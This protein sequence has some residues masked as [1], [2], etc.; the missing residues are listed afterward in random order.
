MRPHPSSVNCPYCGAKQTCWFYDGIDVGVSKC[1]GC[2][3]DM[4]LVQ[5]RI[6]GQPVTTYGAYPLEE[7]EAAALAAKGNVGRTQ[8]PADGGKLAKVA[9]LVKQQ[10][11]KNRG[12]PV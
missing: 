4:K 5:R 7:A 9:A 12:G 11:R 3:R 6:P 10:L 1:R 8:Q 2:G